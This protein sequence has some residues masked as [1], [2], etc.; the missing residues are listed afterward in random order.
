MHLGWQDEP[1]VRGVALAEKL[2]DHAKV[3]SAYR[4]RKHITGS[5]DVS[6]VRDGSEPD[7]LRLFEE[8]QVYEL[9]A[10]RLC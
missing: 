3:S 10:L 2:L 6:Y 8:P 5:E 7:E 9:H 4:I 1:L